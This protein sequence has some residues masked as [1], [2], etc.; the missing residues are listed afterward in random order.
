MES[1]ISVDIIINAISKKIHEIFGDE[2]NI[3]SDEV[4]QGFEAPC[5][6]I[7]LFNGNRKHYRQNRYK[8]ELNFQIVGFAKNDD[9]KQLY[10]MAEGLYDIEFFTIESG[11]IIR[12]FN[13]NHKI[14]NG[15]L[16]FF[17]DVKNFIYSN[18]IETDKMENISV[19]EEVK[20]N[21]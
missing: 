17:F 10:E 3:E 13:M 9:R 14:E 15:V 21:A 5:F 8:S 20:N 4:K 19:K 12:C 7:H 11:D 6:F 1:N 16:Q 2:Y 18:K